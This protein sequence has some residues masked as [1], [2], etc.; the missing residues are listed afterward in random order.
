MGIL[1]SINKMTSG[2]NRTTQTVNSVQSAAR[3]AKNTATS[4]GK[5]FEKK[6]KICKSPLKTDME[7]KKGICA[8]CALSQ[9]K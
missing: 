5:A 2:V 1:D 8:N 4:V 9:M 7:K 3:N 6:C